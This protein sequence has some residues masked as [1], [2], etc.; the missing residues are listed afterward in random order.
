MSG[1]SGRQTSSTAIAVARERLAYHRYATDMARARSIVSVSAPLWLVI[2]LGLHV[3]LFRH[4]GHGPAS[5]VLVVLLAPVPLHVLTLYLLRRDPLPPER[6][7]IPFGGAGFLISAIST[8]FVGTRTGGLA[9]PYH[10]SLL[11]LL[12]IQVL[13]LPRRWQ[14]AGPI[15]LATALTCPLGVLAFSRA[16]PTLRAQLADPVAVDRF[17]GFLMVLGAAVVVTTWASHVLWTLRQSVFESRNIG[18]YKLARRIGRG[19]MGE[20][21]LAHDKVLRRDVALKVMSPDHGGGPAQIARFEREI[22]A[23]AALSHPNTIRIHD[24]GVTAGGVWYYAMELLDGVDLGAL[25]ERRGRLPPPLVA[26][27]GLQTAHAVAEAHARGVVHRDLKPANLFVVTVDGLIDH[28]K[29]LDFGVARVETGEQGMT[30]TGAILG[31]PGYIAPEVAT[32][33][34]AGPASDVW[35]LAATM[36]FALTGVSLRDA[37]GKPA[38]ALVGGIPRALDGLLIRALDPDPARRPASAAA[39]AAELDASGVA[40]TWRPGLRVDGAGL[41]TGEATADT[42]DASGDQLE[43]LADAPGARNRPQSV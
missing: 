22:E 14:E 11:L 39:F 40:A 12:A 6:I 18:R 19:G 3:L 34:P 17:V 23:T 36:F 20:V 8:V 27:L 1:L 24:W 7:M 43:T 26:H 29:V 2:G 31:T 21:W 42:V 4:S 10:E 33:V 32:G 41:T 16:D 25:V 30:Q 15:G 13:G 5:T 35:S 38:S 37:G 28:A 9:S